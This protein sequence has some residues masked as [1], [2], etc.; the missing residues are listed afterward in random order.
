MNKIAILITLMLFSVQAYAETKGD[1]LSGPRVGL[2]YLSSTKVSTINGDKELSSP[3]I[4]QYG[5]QFEKKFLSTASGPEGLV[6]VIP[7]IG[8][9]EQNLFIPSVTLITGIRFRNG[10]EVGAG[11]NISPMGTSAVFTLGHT[12]SIGDLRFPVNLAVAAATTGV[13]VSL[14]VG[15]NSNL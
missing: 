7:L 10:I 3:F 11:P 9:F 4:A 8:G 15:F 12:S 2:T 14:I 1:S 13:R 6:E 5:W